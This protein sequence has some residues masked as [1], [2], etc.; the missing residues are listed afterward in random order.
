M[1]GGRRRCNQRAVDDAEAEAG[2]QRGR[3]PQRIP[4]SGSLESVNPA[5]TDAARIEPTER[6]MPPVG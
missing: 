3:Q 6:W 4:S 5:I 2:E 1:K